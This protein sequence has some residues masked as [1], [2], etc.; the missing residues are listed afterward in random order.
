MNLAFCII[1]G[2][3]PSFIWLMFYLS[4]DSHPEP[5]RM[6]LKIF[7]LGA[8]MGP[9]AAALEGLAVW[10]FEPTVDWRQFLM[11]FD[12][13]DYR[14]F[15]NILLF[16]P[17][18][19]ELLKYSVVRWQVLK[20]PSF[21]EPLDAMIY[22]IVSALGFAAVENLLNVLSAPDFNLKIALSQATARFLSATLLHV[23]SSGLLGYFLALSL[24][25]FKKRKLYLWVGILLAIS[26]H[27]FYNFIAW[28]VLSNALYAA[29]LAILLIS[30]TIL[31]FWQFYRLKKQLSIC[32]IN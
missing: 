25:N 30:L 8:L 28:L 12:K 11:I 2:L 31:I 14:Y 23:L 9:L 5:K 10:V 27:S 26:F 1:L 20:D 7:L 15:L 3:L 21:D 4:K 6:V 16:A 22:L 13:I 29:A 32:K 18:I 17:I 24:L 19:E